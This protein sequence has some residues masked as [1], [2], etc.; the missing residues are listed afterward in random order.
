[1]VMAFVGVCGSLGF[2]YGVVESCREAVNNQP[3]PLPVPVPGPALPIPGPGPAQLQ[4]PDPDR[5]RPQKPP[6]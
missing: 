2:L 5:L 6:Y 3:V 4:V 1:M